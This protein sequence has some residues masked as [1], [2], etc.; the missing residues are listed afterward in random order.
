MN[1]PKIP[2]IREEQKAA[3]KALAA[4]PFLDKGKPSITVAWEPAVPGIPI[5]T[6]GNVSEVV[7]GAKTPIIIANA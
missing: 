2:P 7:V 1:A 4:I 6:A 5:K 3:L